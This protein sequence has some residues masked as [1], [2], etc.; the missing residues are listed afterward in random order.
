MRRRRLR[1]SAAAMLGSALAAVEELGEHKT[2]P[3][4]KWAA[5]HETFWN[6][7]VFEY[8][9]FEW[10]LMQAARTTPLLLLLH[11]IS[12][13]RHHQAFQKQYP[14]VGLKSSSRVKSLSPSCCWS[15]RPPLHHLSSSWPYLHFIPNTQNN[16]LQKH[17]KNLLPFPSHSPHTKLLPFQT[18]QKKYRFLRPISASL[19]T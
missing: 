1:Q 7:E 6:E 15:V 5:S 13:L 2:S 4:E 11:F 10:C 16:G 3:A 18:R 14:W 17:K 8:T 12:L 19:H 9:L